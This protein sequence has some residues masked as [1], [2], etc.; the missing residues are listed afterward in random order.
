MTVSGSTLFIFLLFI[1]PT[2]LPAQQVK[3]IDWQYEI[4]LLGKELSQKHKDLYF[5]TDSV[6]FHSALDKIASEAEGQSLFRVSLLLQ[7]AMAR[8]ADDQTR[9]NYHFNI[10]ADA[11][12]PIALYWFEDGI[13]VLKTRKEFNQILGKKLTAIN[14]FPL[15]TVIDSLATL[16]VKDNNA[17]LRAEIPRMIVWTQLLE[18]FGF[19]AR[20]SILI[21]V[22]DQDGTLIHQP[23]RLPA[24]ES[25]YVSVQ[26]E[27]LPLGWQ[28]RKSFFREH[29]LPDEKIYYIQYNKCWSREAEEKFGTGATALFMPSFKEF[30]KLVFQNIKK[31]EID[32][33][34]F[35]LRLNDGGNAL[36]GTRFIKKLCKTKFNG[37]GEFYV[38]VGRYTSSSAIIN[39]VDFMK[40]AKVVIIGEETGGRPNH[41]GEVKRFVLPESRLV[42]SYPT[43]YFS[44]LD[45]DPPT[46]K[47]EIITPL[48]FDDYLKG[49]DTAMEAVIN[50]H[51]K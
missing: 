26:P 41:Y 36:Q 34:V 8:M 37:Q 50:H 30:E 38:L 13:Y 11:I 4:N 21:E 24:N 35:D 29:Y 2:L 17:L 49:R 28:D 14:G 40:R 32:K 18:N 6:T 15:R 10:D 19:A 51:F 27:Q 9:I 48:Y 22:E 5:K 16:L 1:A 39:S 12:L 44:L 43:R 33:I 20:D 7:Q 47:P 31:Y 46:L 23:F 3:E 25:E 42:V 45:T